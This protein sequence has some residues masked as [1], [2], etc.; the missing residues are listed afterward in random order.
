MLLLLSCF[1]AKITASIGSIRL[2][3]EEF[4]D[5]SHRN[6]IYNVENE[7]TSVYL[8]AR[9]SRRSSVIYLAV[10]LSCVLA[11]VSLFFVEVHVSEQAPAIVRPATEVSVVRS[12]VNGRIRACKV[13][14]NDLVQAGDVLFIIDSPILLEKE[15]ELVRKRREIRAFIDDLHL[16]TSSIETPVLHT[17]LYRQAHRSYTQKVADAISRL[18]K[19]EVDL[20]R[21]SKLH[22]Q[23][24]I[25]DAEYEMYRFEYDKARSEVDILAQAQG[26]QWQTDLRTYEQEERDVETQLAQLRTEQDNQ[27]VRAPVGGSIQNISHLYA[28][29][30]VFSNQ[31]LGQ[32]S[33]ETS[34][35]VEVYVTPNDIGFIELNMPVS[36]QVAAFNHHQWG[37]A[38][39]YVKEISRDVHVVNDKPVF[40]VKCLLERDYLQLKN[41]YKGRLKKGMTLQAHFLITK[42]TLWQL[43]Y[44]KVDDWLNPNTVDAAL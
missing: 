23:Q 1:Y 8:Y 14:E 19:A 11:F 30:V 37:L 4:M 12:M 39:G 26:T 43:L 21:N 25:A 34:L 13:K 9:Y 35:Q 7:Q 40:K 17:P 5:P 38:Q 27:V 10:C 33:P 20:K 29:T 28:G 16:L 41:G 32:I 15:N 24:V 36:F 18:A 44:D 42:R 31:D 3:V 2:S 22:D 6:I